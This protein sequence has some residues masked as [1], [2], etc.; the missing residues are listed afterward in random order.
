[1]NRRMP[2]PVIDGGVI[3]DAELAELLRRTAAELRPLF[4]DVD[5]ARRKQLDAVAA[6]LESVALRLTTPMPDPASRRLL[7]DAVQRDDAGAALAAAR[8]V[9]AVERRRMPSQDW[10]LFG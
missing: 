10:R 4:A 1:M 9:V 2:E 7:A 5:P 8:A 6:L 3:D